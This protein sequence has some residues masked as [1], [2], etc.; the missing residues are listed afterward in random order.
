MDYIIENQSIKAHSLLLVDIGLD[1]E[2]AKEQLKTASENKEFE[3]EKVILVSNIG[4]E[5][6]KIVYNELDELPSEISK[7]FCF[8]IPGEMH[9]L[10]KEFLESLK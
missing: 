9:D 5:K 2:K 3:L 10:E 1:L 6:Q 7:P 8:I 4:T